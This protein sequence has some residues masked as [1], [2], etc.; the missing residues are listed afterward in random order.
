MY[1]ELS[2]KQGHHLRHSSLSRQLKDLPLV[3]SLMIAGSTPTSSLLQRTG[4]IRIS[5]TLHRL[6][7]ATGGRRRPGETEH[8]A[9]APGACL[10]CAA[11]D[12]TPPTNYDRAK[13][14]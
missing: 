5:L 3:L 7:S 2:N 11:L 1:P 10:R 12:R 9:P 8:Q 4:K 14:G 6:P 13:N